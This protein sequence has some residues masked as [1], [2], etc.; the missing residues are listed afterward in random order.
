MPFNG[1]CRYLALMVRRIIGAMKDP[2]QLDDKD[3]YG[4]KRLELAGQLMSLLFEELFKDFVDEFQKT[5]D[6]ELGKLAGRRKDTKEFDANSTMWFNPERIT[7]GLVSRL[8]SGVW[9]L[10]R[11]RMNRQGVTQ[12]LSR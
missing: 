6:K 10:K 4:N 11:F 1:K 7:R 2:S 3:Y 8:S 9:D 12:V 5:I